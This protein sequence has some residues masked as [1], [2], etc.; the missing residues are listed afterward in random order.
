MIGGDDS[1][2]TIRMPIGWPALDDDQPASAI[3]IPALYTSGQTLE[4]REKSAI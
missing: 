2:E 1:S 4:T 3:D